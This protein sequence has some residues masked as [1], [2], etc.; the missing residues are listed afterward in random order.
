[1]V[2]G[3]AKTLT[4]KGI[5]VDILINNA[6]IDPKVENEEGVLATSRLDN[7][8]IEQW[9]LQVSVGMTGAFL[10]SQVFGTAMSLNGKAGVIVNIA[11]GLLVF[12]PNQRLYR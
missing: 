10:C 6:T 2:R 9:N 8:T 3:V 7:F 11:S 12:A 5:R 1:M 4:E